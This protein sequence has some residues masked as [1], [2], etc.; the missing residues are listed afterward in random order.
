M[1]RQRMKTPASD[2]RTSFTSKGTPVLMS[3]QTTVARLRARDEQALPWNDEAVDR[4]DPSSRKRVGEYW[5]GR[6]GA[7]L[8]VAAAFADFA[9]KLERTGTEPAVL[10]LIVA[11]IDN[12]LYHAHLCEQLATRYLGAKIPAPQAGPVHLPELAGVDDATRTALYAAGL[13]AINES[14]ATVWLKHCL[15]RS[16]TPLSRAVNQLHLSDE[17]SHARV[18]W[19]HLASNWVS[20]PIRAEVARRLVALIRGNVTQWLESS[21]Q[22]GGGVPDHGL[23]DPSEQRAYVLEA[24]RDLVIPGFD[25]VGINVSEAKRWFDSEFG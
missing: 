3:I 1:M 22:T 10:E 5:Q 17:I 16:A 19:A 4:L 25:Y 20:P 21:T 9:G 6:A 2:S 24:V 8:R 18:G 13:C 12:E 14:I 7:E 23:P 11:S 15:E